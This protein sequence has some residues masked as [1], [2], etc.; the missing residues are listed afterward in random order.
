MIHTHNAAISNQSH[1]SSYASLSLCQHI[2]PP[3]NPQNR[4]HNASIHS[5]NSQLNRIVVRTHM[6]LCHCGKP[7]D[8]QLSLPFRRL[9]IYVVSR[10]KN[11]ETSNGDDDAI[12]TRIIE[13]DGL[14][15]WHHHCPL[16]PADTHTYRT[17]VVSNITTKTI[18]P[19]HGHDI[20]ERW[21]GTSE[22]R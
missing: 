18:A 19:S 1:R 14:F 13:I 20:G 8:W 3:K 22:K 7:T 12:Q 9:L 6:E 5:P 2:K 10:R 15:K 21:S 4:T 16:A 17:D 11:D